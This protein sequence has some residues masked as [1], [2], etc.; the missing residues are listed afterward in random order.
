MQ[1]IYTS[2]SIHIPDSYI[3]IVFCE[4]IP[5]VSISDCIV[6]RIR[7][8]PQSVR[9]RLSSVRL[10][11]LPMSSCMWLRQSLLARQYLR[12]CYMYVHSLSR[13]RSRITKNNGNHRASDDCIVGKYVR[14][15]Q[16]NTQQIKHSNIFQNLDQAY[17]YFVLLCLGGEM[18][19][20]MDRTGRKGLF[21]ALYS[22]HSNLQLVVPEMLTALMTSHHGA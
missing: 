21:F 7:K 11:L 12:K 8:F 2:F 15:T 14:K 1:F 10:P 20:H 16:Q 19:L 17:M 6:V 13:V 5:R 22:Q 18:D 4:Y 9:M 3:I